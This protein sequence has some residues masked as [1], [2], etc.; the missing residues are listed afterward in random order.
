MKMK[1]KSPNEDENQKSE[2]RWKYHFVGGGG[3]WKRADL[4]NFQLSGRRFQKWKMITL[5]FSWRRPISYRSQSIDFLRKSMDWFLY[6]IGLRQERL[7]GGC[8]YSVHYAAFLSNLCVMF[9]S[10]QFYY[11][12]WR[13]F[14][15]ILLF[16]CLASI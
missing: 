5:T 13:C 3:Y 7:M 15:V 11:N 4:Q 10:L 1:I 12:F 16:D 8:D 14:T 9:I 6:D 2:L